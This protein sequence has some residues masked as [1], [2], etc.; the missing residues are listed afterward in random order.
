MLTI[1]GLVV[2]QRTTK[3]GK[4]LYLVLFG[5]GNFV[6][7]LTNKTYELMKVVEFSTDKFIANDRQLILLD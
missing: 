1:K 4:N 6:K 5:N 7:I 3:K 2:S